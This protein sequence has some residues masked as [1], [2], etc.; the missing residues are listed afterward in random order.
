MRARGSPDSDDP[1][2]VEVSGIGQVL[3]TAHSFRGLALALP[4]R[5]QQTRQLDHDASHSPLDGERACRCD[6]GGRS[7]RRPGHHASRCGY[8]SR[9]TD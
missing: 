5:R 7:S 9:P 6:P 2:S 3:R 4:L 1:A 8:T